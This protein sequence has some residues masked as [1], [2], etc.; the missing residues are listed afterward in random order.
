MTDSI[1]LNV[2]PP[3][4]IIINAASDQT[5]KIE[6]QPSPIIEISTTTVIKG[7]DGEKGE[8]GDKGDSGAYFEYQQLLPSQVWTIAHNLNKYPSVTVTD[9]LKNVVVSDVTYVDQ[10][11]LQIKHG[12]P[13]IGFTYCK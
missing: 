8:K 5:I 1:I 11:T 10:N 9:H 3:D 13:L 12:I 7:V 4:Q 2:H 6:Q